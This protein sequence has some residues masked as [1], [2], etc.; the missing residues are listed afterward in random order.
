MTKEKAYQDKMRGIIGEGYNKL[1]LIVVSKDGTPVSHATWRNKFKAI[2]K[3]NN[4]PMIRIHDLR[5]QN[6]SIVIREGIPVEFARQRTG[7]TAR[8]ALEYTHM[9]DMSNRMAAEKINQILENE[10]ARD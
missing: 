8:T 9:D 3:E 6:M 2:L 5:H 4:L 7:Q 10:R 1:N